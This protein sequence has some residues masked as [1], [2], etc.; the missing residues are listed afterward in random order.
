M[1]NSIID[2]LQKMDVS[3]LKM[4]NG[5]T[6]GTELQR[7]AKI[8]ADCIQG[9]MDKMYESYQPKQYHRTYRLYD[10]LY[11]DDELIFSASAK[12][13]SLKIRLGFDNGSMHIGFNGQPADT[14]VLLNDGYKTSGYFAHIPYLGYREGYH[15]VEKGIEDYR[16]KVSNPFTV[17]ISK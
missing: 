2:Q 8:L 11:I 4:A 17:E 6:V 9:Q 10:S 13:S 15:F 3:K 12:G 5:S 1:Q 16:R 7:H 14:A